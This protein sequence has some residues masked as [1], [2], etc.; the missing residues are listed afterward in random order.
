M[1]DETAT[2][3]RPDTELAEIR[4]R[5]SELVRWRHTINE[6]I[7]QLREQEERAEDHPFN[8]AEPSAH[9]AVR[10]AFRSL[11]PDGDAGY[12]EAS[13][14]ETATQ[15]APH[16]SAGEIETAL[17]TMQLRGEVYYPTEGYVKQT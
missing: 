9:S 10:L 1:T 5:I 12:S 14:V 17:E 16:R 8:E 2:D 7:D 3:N 11:D 4:G 15:M 13:V 6:R